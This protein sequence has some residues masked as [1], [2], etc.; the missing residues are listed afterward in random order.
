MS[1][2]A[3]TKAKAAWGADIPDWV[4]ALAEAC[5]ETSQNK[6]AAVIGNSSTVVSRVLANAYPGNVDK[7]A[8]KVQGVYLAQNLICPVLGEI[9]R[10]RC[11][12]EQD[13]PLTF[14]NPVRPRVH[15]ACRGGCKH[16]SIGRSK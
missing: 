16:S 2:T 15:A 12:R 5:D 8:Q 10:A 6:V 13:L 3:V 14:Q 9:S 11:V 4:I 7:I 1:T